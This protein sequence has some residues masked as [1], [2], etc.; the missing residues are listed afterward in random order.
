MQPE[1]ESDQPAAAARVGDG[2]GPDRPQAGI[3]ADVPAQK[4][5]APESPQR[6]W[7]G[8]TWPVV[9]LLLLLVGIVWLGVHH[10]QASDWLLTRGYHPSAA[11]DKM[12]TEDTMTPYARQLF[13][14]NKPKVEDRDEFNKHCSNASDQVSVLG[15]YTGNRQGIYVYNVTESQL[16]GI[17]QVTAAHEMLHQ[18]YDRLSGKERTALDKQL[19]A[20]AKTIT[21][22]V[23]LSKIATYKQTEPHDV[24]N[25]YH[26]LF[27]T[28]VRDLP[29]GLENYYKRYFAKRSAVVDQHDRYQSV[30]NERTQQIAAY[31]VQLSDMKKQLEA[32]KSEI[33]TEEAA[34]KARRAQMDAWLAS[35]NIASYNAAVPGFNQQVNDYKALVS[36]ANTRIHQYNE[37]IDARNKIAVEEQRLQS[38]IDSHA[39]SASRQ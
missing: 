8:R 36:A 11:I 32:D 33:A 21:D 3:S 14:V 37:I 26:S 18:A 12:A 20:Y 39:S 22:P 29:S 19:E 38:A 2:T 27:G 24:V 9:A 13:F 30:F 6:G 16:D 4:P 10:D 34:L 5:A 28:E 17:Q 7:F 25:E 1:S 35:N 23:L 31:D 15:C